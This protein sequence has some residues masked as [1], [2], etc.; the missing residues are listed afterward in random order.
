MRRVSG[1]FNCWK[2]GDAVRRSQ[3]V[4]FINECPGTLKYHFAATLYGVS[5]SSHPRILS[6]LRL[7]AS[8][9]PVHGHTVPTL[10]ARQQVPIRMTRVAVSYQQK[11]IKI[12]FKF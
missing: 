4:Q 5:D 2:I 12:K 8:Y 7:F 6:E 10:F 9:Y 1:A 3:D 11:K